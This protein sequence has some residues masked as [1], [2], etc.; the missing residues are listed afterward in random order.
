[1]SKQCSGVIVFWLLLFAPA[2]CGAQEKV[3]S[4]SQT[5]ALPNAPQAQT[6]S[7]SSGSSWNNVLAGIKDAQPA[8][9]PR[10]A[11]LPE[12]TRIKLNLVTPVSSKLPSGSS[13]QA[14]LEEPLATKG[15]QQDLLPKGTLFEGHVECRRAGRMMRPGSMFM[16]FDRVILPGGEVYEVNV[17]LVS[18]ESRAVKTDSEGKLHPALSKKRLAIQFGG[19]ALT[20]K[21]ADDLAELA[22]GEAV[23]AGKARMLGASAAATFFILQKGREVKLQRGDR[24]ELEFGRSVADSSGESRTIR[25]PE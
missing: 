25:T 6:A 16:A 21:L 3:Q 20:A 4:D 14:R 12:G 2:F 22:G 23:S 17:N 24:L 9:M 15:T 7:P 11:Q 10:P 19:T 8:L 13:F 1:V 18:A 5:E